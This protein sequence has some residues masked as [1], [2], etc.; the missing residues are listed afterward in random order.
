MKYKF[1][2]KVDLIDIITRENIN[3]LVKTLSI[4][5]YCYRTNYYSNRDIEIKGRETINECPRCL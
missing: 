4:M 3:R 1:D 5:K 2:K